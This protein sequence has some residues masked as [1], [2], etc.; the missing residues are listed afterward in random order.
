MSNGS[1]ESFEFSLAKSRVAPTDVFLVE[2]ADA[3]QEHGLDRVVGI[4][5]A[6]PPQHLW[7]EEL[8]RTGMI[9]SKAAPEDMAMAE[10]YITTQWAFEETSAGLGMKAVKACEETPAGHRRTG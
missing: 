6:L 10:N 8:S 7:K 1:F 4:T 2:L 3:L 9:C 5:K